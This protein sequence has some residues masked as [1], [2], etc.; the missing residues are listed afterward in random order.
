MIRCCVQIGASGTFLS[1]NQILFGFDG[2]NGRVD[3]HLVNAGL[4]AVPCML[5]TTILLG[6]AARWI[7]MANK[8]IDKKAKHIETKH[9]EN[10]VRAL[11]ISSA[12]RACSAMVSTERFPSRP[13]FAGVAIGS[14]G[15]CMVLHG[16]CLAVVGWWGAAP[17]NARPHPHATLHG[18]FLLRE[19]ECSWS[20][21][22]SVLFVKIAP[23]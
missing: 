1:H 2:R 22:S 12:H 3:Y 5:L 4:F 14:L 17:V 11:A 9:L 18:G 7:D 23:P 19:C 20:C 10:E 6:Y 15:A 13:T 16:G 21:S 8:K